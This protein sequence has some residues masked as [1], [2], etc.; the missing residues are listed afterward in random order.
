M[1]FIA[2]IIIGTAGVGL[3]LF[4]S[5]KKVSVRWYEAVLAIVGVGLVVLGIHDFFASFSEYETRA[6]WTFLVMF[7]LTGTFMLAVAAY[8]P[9]A[10][11]RKKN[12]PE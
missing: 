8:L 12:R 1:W 10:R 3:A 5:K 11:Y 7:T 2:G 9:W 4:L 6:A